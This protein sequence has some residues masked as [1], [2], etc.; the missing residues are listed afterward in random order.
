MPEVLIFQQF[1][2]ISEIFA[3]V[4]CNELPIVYNRGRGEQLRLAG[5]IGRVTKMTTANQM[6]INDQIRMLLHGYVID[7]N[8]L[9]EIS[10]PNSATRN[11]MIALAESHGL[12]V[13]IVGD[14]VRL[15]DE[16]Y[17][18]AVRGGYVKTIAG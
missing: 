8:T 3:K 13:D 12:S 9:D 5:R 11:Q 1:T 14:E 10:V 6:T 2:T 16:C 7:R 17:T 18:Y 15:S 4:A